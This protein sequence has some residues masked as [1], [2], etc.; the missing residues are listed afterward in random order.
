MCGF[1]PTVGS[2]PTATANDALQHAA[3]GTTPSAEDVHALVSV[4][5]SPLCALA[6]RPDLVRHAPADRPSASPNGCWASAGAT[7]AF[8]RRRL[9]FATCWVGATAMGGFAVIGI[10][11]SQSVYVVAALDVVYLFTLTFAG[12]CSASLRQQLTPDHLLGRVTSAFWTIHYAAS[13]LGAALLTAAIQHYSTAPVLLFAGSVCAVV[14]LCG[15]LTP[16]R[17]QE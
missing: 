11:Y 13:P 9:R 4:P 1:T 8:A 2:N 16:I 6:G 12:T 17:H 10:G 5:A 3:S 15:L 14:A 7:V